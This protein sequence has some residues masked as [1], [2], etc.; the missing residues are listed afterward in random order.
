MVGGSG[1]DTMLAGL[2]SDTMSG[3]A[4]SNTFAFFAANTGGAHDIIT[5]FNAND[6]VYLI[7]Y[8]PAQTAS[9]LQDA[10]TVNASGVTLTLSDNTQITFTD[11]S[12]V[13]TL[14]GHILYVGGTA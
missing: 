6:A 3:G 8:D 13:Q 5:D 4:G 9:T 7:G 1:S 10:A 14:D 11:L 12:N 2:G